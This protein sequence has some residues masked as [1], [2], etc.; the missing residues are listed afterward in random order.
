[1]LEKG[2]GGRN[3]DFTG[4]IGE[5]HNLG[6][7]HDRR[8]I[9]HIARAAVPKKCVLFLSFLHLSSSQGAISNTGEEK[10]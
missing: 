5:K 1:M 2:G 6:I 10:R 4:P 9:F 8:P 7:C 3:G